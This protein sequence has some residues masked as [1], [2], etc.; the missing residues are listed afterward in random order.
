MNLVKVVNLDSGK[1][2]FPFTMLLVEGSSE[3]GLFR[4]LSNHV[5]WSPSVKKYIHYEGQFFLKVFKIESKFRKRKKKFRIYFWFW[6]NFIW[7][8]CYKFSLIRSEYLLSAL[9]ASRNSPMILDISQRNF[10]PQLYSQRSINM[11]KDVSF[12]FENCFGPFTVLLVEGSS[13]T[14]LFRNLSNHVFW[15]P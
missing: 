5:F 3:T 14:G 8:C 1:C 10:K 2:F 12:R 6:D 11:V 7:K 9:N 4:H 13:E 15:S